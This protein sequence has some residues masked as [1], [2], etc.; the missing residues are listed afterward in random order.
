MVL[1][2]AQPVNWFFESL[3]VLCVLSIAQHWLSTTLDTFEQAAS[4]L[5]LALPALFDDLE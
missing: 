4:A 2:P 3:T 1:G 5:R